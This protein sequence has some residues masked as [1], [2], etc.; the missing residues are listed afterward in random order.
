MNIQDVVASILEPYVNYGCAN[1][2]ARDLLSELR[3]KDIVVAHQ[4]ELIAAI[5][6][7]VEEII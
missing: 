4:G 1:N 6:R 5:Q 3:G 7:R 2:V